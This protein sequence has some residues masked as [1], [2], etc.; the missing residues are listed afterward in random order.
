MP[1]MVRYVC[2]VVIEKVE[3]RKQTVRAWKDGDEVKTKEESLGWFITLAGTDASISL[4][5]EK[6]D[7]EPMQRIQLILQSIPKKGDPK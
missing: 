2:E 7:F 5:P 4:G 6:P 1:P 3:E